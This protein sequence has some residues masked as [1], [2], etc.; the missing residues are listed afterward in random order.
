MAGKRHAQTSSSSD[1]ELPLAKRHTKTS[2]RTTPQEEDSLQEEPV[3]IKVKE[4]ENV[5]DIYD[6]D[7]DDENP[8][9]D[10]A[11]DNGTAVIDMESKMLVTH[12]MKILCA[13]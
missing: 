12:L 8:K 2:K 4:K 3:P 5:D 7:F 10:S 9:N 1:L 11:K 13:Q 6:V